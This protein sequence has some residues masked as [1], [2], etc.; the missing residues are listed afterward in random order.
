[1]DIKKAMKTPPRSDEFLVFAADISLRRP[2]FALIKWSNGKP[3]LLIKN[4]VDNRHTDITRGMALERTYDALNIWLQVITLNKF[5][6][7]PER[8]LPVYLVREQ[9]IPAHR[10]LNEI[11]IFEAIGITTMWAWTKLHAE[12]IDIHPLVIKE[13]VTGDGKADKDAVAKAVNEYFP[14]ARFE[15][16]DE[17]DAC[18]VGLSFL[19]SV[20]L[21]PAQKWPFETR[22]KKT[23][24]ATVRRGTSAQTK[25]GHKALSKRRGIGGKKQCTKITVMK[26]EKSPKITVMRSETKV[27]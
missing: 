3:E 14:E 15:T 22:K 23:G 24:G 25:N 2:G 20:G 13:I 18:A 12:W 7:N 26:S 11:G 4:N 16:D 9:G 17:S 8:E 10:S 6:H 21:L 27:G 5:W 19:M 1:M